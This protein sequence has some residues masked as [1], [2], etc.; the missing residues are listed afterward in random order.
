MQKHKLKN[1]L[2]LFD[3]TKTES[4]N[5]YQNGYRKIFDCGNLVYL[6]S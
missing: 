3:E 1:I 5:C 6:H 4:E 2:P